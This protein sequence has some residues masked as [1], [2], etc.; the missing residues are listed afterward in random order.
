MLVTVAVYRGTPPQDPAALPVVPG[1]PP[2]L[3]KGTP[4]YALARGTLA[5]GD[6]YGE[7]KLEPARGPVRLSVDSAAYGPY[8]QK[9]AGEYE[10]ARSAV[11]GLQGYINGNYGVVYSFRLRFISP[12]RRSYRLLLQPSGGSGHYALRAKGEAVDSPYLSHRGAW[13][14]YDAVSYGSTEAL[15]ETSLPG[16][17]YGPQKLFFIPETSSG[18]AGTPRPLGQGVKEFDPSWP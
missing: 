6:R 1:T 12:A 14:F 3:I 13:W 7:L 15:L 9:M 4:Y 5:H 2:K 11:D 10:L 16:G 17:S 8:S 18:A